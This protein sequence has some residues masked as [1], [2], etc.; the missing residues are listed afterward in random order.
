MLKLHS[1]GA[2]SDEVQRALGGEH[3]SVSP[4]TT[5]LHQHGYIEPLL[6]KDGT[7][8]KRSTRRGRQPA[9]V[10]IATKRGIEVIRLGLPIWVGKGDPT[11]RKHKGNPQSAVAF[12]ATD[13]SVLRRQVLTEFVRRTS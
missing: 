3:Q 9:Q 5:E 6:D 11:A 7:S 1:A 2:T 4:R 13:R 10:W 8:I 12:N